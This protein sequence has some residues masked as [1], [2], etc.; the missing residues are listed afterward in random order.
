L[1]AAHQHVRRLV[2]MADDAL[3]EAEGEGAFGSDSDSVLAKAAIGSLSHVWNVTA[4]S[5]DEVVANELM[6]AVTDVA[7][8]VSARQAGQPIVE[9]VARIIRETSGAMAQFA[10]VL[11]KLAE[12]IRKRVAGIA[13]LDDAA[14]RLVTAYASAATATGLG[15]QIA[16]L[17][18][19]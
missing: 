10:T 11:P 13:D 6:P 18:G 8:R 1:F 17:G 16:K 9:D 5:L 3:A 15:A 4:D 19:L 12:R 7:R 2:G 14:D